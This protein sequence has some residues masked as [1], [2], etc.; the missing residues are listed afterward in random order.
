MKE[1]ELVATETLVFMQAWLE[2]HRELCRYSGEALEGH[3]VEGHPAWCRASQAADFKKIWLLY[4]GS[5]LVLDGVL[6]DEMLELFLPRQLDLSGRSSGSLQ[7]LGMEFYEV[8]CG[9]VD[10]LREQIQKKQ[11]AHSWP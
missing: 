11:G 10:T 3:R 5:L 6:P 7:V 2:T 1:A 8:L 9:A 4:R